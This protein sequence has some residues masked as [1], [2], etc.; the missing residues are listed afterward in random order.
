M[1]KKMD[2]ERYCQCRPGCTKSLEGYHQNRKYHPDHVEYAHKRIQNLN[3]KK[4][5]GSTN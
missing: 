1:K 5:A 3:I 2:C 4:S